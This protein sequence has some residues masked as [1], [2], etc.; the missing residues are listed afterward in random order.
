MVGEVLVHKDL[1]LN[2]QRLCKML[3][4]VACAYHPELVA[5]KRASLGLAGQLFLTVSELQAQ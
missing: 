3:G 1:G 4:M 2:R 5:Q